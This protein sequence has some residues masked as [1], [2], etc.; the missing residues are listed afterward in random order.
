VSSINELKAEIA[1]NQRRID[2][3]ESYERGEA[4]QRRRKHGNGEWH[5]V[6]I[7]VPGWDFDNFEFRKKP[8][9]AVIYCNRHYAAGIDYYWKAYD[10]IGVCRAFAG[11]DALEIAV[12]FVRVEE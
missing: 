2:I 4:I 1:E 9:P 11:S 3:I 7:K 8:E 10:D 6:V 5:S 12:K